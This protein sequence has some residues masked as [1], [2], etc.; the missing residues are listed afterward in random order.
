MV[1]STPFFLTDLWSPKA[2]LFTITALTSQGRRFSNLQE[3][4]LLKCDIRNCFE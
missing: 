3:S 4:Y 2:S 1:T